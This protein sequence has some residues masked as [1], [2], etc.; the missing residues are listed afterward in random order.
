MDLEFNEEEA[1]LRD[2]LREIVDGIS[3]PAAVRDVYEGGDAAAE[4][5]RRMVELDWPGL[6]IAKEHGGIGMGFLEL[7]IVAEQLGRATVPGPFLSTATQFAPAICAL[8]DSPTRQRLL[9]DVAAG[10]CTGALAMAEA[11]SWRTR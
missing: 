10:R 2:S 9:P 4:V 5:W 3:P 11:G 7:A 1:A 8:A 6:A